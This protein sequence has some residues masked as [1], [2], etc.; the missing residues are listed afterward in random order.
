MADHPTFKRRLGAMRLLRA[1]IVVVPLV[2]ALLH[3]VDVFHLGF[4]ARLDLAVDDARQR[5]TLPR[6]LDPRI[7]IVDID[8]RSLRELGR[9]PWGRDRLAALTE[10]L[11]VRQRAGVIGFDLVFAEPDTSSGLP[12][13]E[14]L[15][16]NDPALAARLPGLRER[17]DHDARFARA[18]A[19][20]HAVLGYYLSQDPATVSNG[21][22]P[23][24][25][26]EA[27]AL[28]GRPSPFLRWNAYVANLPAL[29]A[30]APRGG[31]FN[32]LP[33][34]DG[35]TRS[36]PLV[37][38][39]AGRH[40]EALALAMFRSYTGNPSLAPGY[41]TSAPDAPLDHLTLAQGA[42]RARIA[43]DER[44]AARVPFR[45]PGGPQGGSYRY[46]SAA[47][48]LAGRLAPGSLAG[49]LVLVG[50]SAPALFDRRST[51]V[52]AVD[53]GVEVHANLLSG[54]LDGRLPSRPD[55]APGYEV[56]L[57]LAIAGA[58]A[59]ALPRLAAVPTLMVW[60]A[61]W[62]AL[63]GANLWA[64]RALG[65]VLP[66]APVLLYS[67]LV[68]AGT[69]S[70]GYAVEGR[71][72]RSLTRLFGTYV[73]P[74]LVARMA[75]DPR[76]YAMAAENRVLTVMFCDMRNFTRVSEA[77]EPEALR[78]LVN[79]FFSAMTAVIR[80]QQGTLDKYIGD[81]IMA[82]WGA[83]LDDPEHARHAVRA[84]LEMVQALAGVNAHLRE[85]QLPEI[86][87]GLGVNTGLV[88][89]GDMG[90]DIRR[91][92][93]VMGDAVNLASRIEALTRH[94]GL[95]LL[96]GEA[97]RDACGDAHAWLEVDRV[98]VKGKQTSVTLF[99]PVPTDHARLH[100]FAEESR[101]WRLALEQYRRQ[102][103]EAA[104]DHI[105]RLLAASPSPSPFAALY[106]QLADRIGHLRNHPPSPDWDG[107]TSFATK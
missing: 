82:F 72:R 53:P 86:G 39:V 3:A 4:V 37:A 70:W 105:D 107:T 95:D 66:L 60:S 1:A 97:T 59:W 30:A 93:T 63:I 38:Q 42:A 49:R 6:T 84:A 106:R 87:I 76:R 101:L 51:P 69:M 100:S 43:V 2:V 22:L 55:W 64:W 36:V 54:L 56:V 67:A 88:C 65:L 17:L 85:R 74:E 18:L 7:V 9:W 25:P 57:L 11:F 47:E 50:S 26:F 27:D 45:G 8:E 14:A 12:V 28:G 104:Q 68:F 32:W 78:E 44:G 16:A 40:G 103:W 48:V 92:Y 90:S 91:S 52:E 62:I 41:A 24:P 19:R 61:L 20:G 80:R 83:P 75:R 33:D 29:V 46:V 71:T 99:T 15:A 77:L 5:W 35:V 58:L 73:P 81:A 23:A 98:R 31:Y 21:T 13:I 94:Y 102:H 96:V 10:E 34:G 89:V 79:R